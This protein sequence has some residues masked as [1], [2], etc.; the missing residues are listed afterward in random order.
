[1]PSSILRRAVLPLAVLLTLLITGPALADSDAPADLGLSPLGQDG[2]WFD[3]DLEPSE[4]LDLQV[5]LANHGAQTVGA[6][7][8]LA[9]VYSLINGGM[10]VSLY[11]EPADDP[12]TG[13]IDY[14]TSTPMLESDAA[15]HHT[16]TV[17]VPDA[18]EP[19]QYIAALVI[20][21][22][23]DGAEDTDDLG[24][25]QVVRQ[26][27]AVNI[28][29]PGPAAPQIE[30][31]DT[32]HLLTAGNSTLRTDLDNSGNRHLVPDGGLELVGPDGQTVTEQ[33]LDLAIV[34]AHTSTQVETVLDH[35]L[36]PGTYTLTTTLADSS[37]DVETTRTSTFE[38]E[39][40][41]PEL[42]VPGADRVVEILDSAGLRLRETL[43]ALGLLLAGLLIVVVRRRR[44]R[45]RAATPLPTPGVA[46]LPTS[47][48]PPVAEPAGDDPVPPPAPT[49][50][51]EPSAPLQPTEP[52]PTPAGIDTS[53][54][55]AH[56]TSPPRRRRR[57]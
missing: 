13:W 51:P 29:V 8:Y 30:L 14:P 16:V 23:P 49:T 5:E 45:R 40:P 28:T 57:R 44:G 6:R 17:T 50:P 2:A 25:D 26:A 24:I 52:R 35:E 15:Q 27:V 37:H 38:I 1:M 34:Y 41:A 33:E 18:A 21:H 36:E 31:G 11:D 32:T 48:P 56:G 42:A 20:E 10:G 22:Q 12:V 53:L 7:S 47:P 3:L 46:P 4:Q 43:I 9:D 54:F 19:G 55:A 39:A